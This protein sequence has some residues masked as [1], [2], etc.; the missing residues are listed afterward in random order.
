LLIAG[1]PAGSFGT[2]CYVI[3]PAAG[4]RCVVVDPGQDAVDGVADILREHRL[5]PAAVVLTHGHLDHM[6]SVLPVCGAHDVP[7][8]IHPADRFMLADPLRGVSPQFAAMVG[9]DVTFAEPDEV[10]ELVDG[11]ALGLGGVLGFDLVVDHAPGHTKGSVTFTLPRLDAAGD[12]D[13]LFSGD[14]LFAGSIGRS[15]LPGGDPAELN[16]SLARVVLPRPDDTLVLP[17]HGGSTTIGRERASNPFLR[18]LKSVD[19]ARPGL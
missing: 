11:K 17:G 4:E 14:L 10:R 7:A 9:P 13:V 3:A 15:D 5:L 8:Y 18:G 1:F 6:W 16:D 19:S 2:N 12:P